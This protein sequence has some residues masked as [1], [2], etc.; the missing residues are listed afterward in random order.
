MSF[1]HSLLFY[2]L[3]FGRRVLQFAG[4]FTLGNSQRTFGWNG[5]SSA[6]RENPQRLV[7]SAKSWLCHPE[8][9]KQAILPLYAPEDLNKISAVDAATAY[10]QHLRGLG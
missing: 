9:Q 5:R 1:R 7:S 2:V 6:G 10:L 3:P 8:G 4:T